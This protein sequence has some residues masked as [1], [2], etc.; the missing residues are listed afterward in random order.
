[1]PGRLSFL[2]YE[3]AYFFAHFGALL[4]FSLRTEGRHNIPRR[5]PALVV[6]NHQSF[7]DPI[8]V[9]L[10]TRRHLRALARKTLYQHAF[11]A[12]VIDALDAIP[13]DHEGVG[14]EG[15]KIVLEE[16]GRGRGV[17]V[18]PEGTRARDGRLHALRPGIHLL[19]K[20]VQAPIV[21]VG[22]AGAYEAWPPGRKYPLPAPLFLPAN[23]RTLAVSVGKPLDGRRY[24]ALPRSQALAELLQELQKLTARAERLRR[25]P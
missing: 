1:M 7:L 12:R 16:L 5:G 3:T 13:I 25:K 9:G 19:I 2:W 14:K 4:G 20:R 10:S 11:V 15:L 6:A 8:L 17:L 22:I 18:F 21:P 23:R 24:A